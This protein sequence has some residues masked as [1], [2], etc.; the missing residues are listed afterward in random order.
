MCA[1]AEAKVAVHENKMKIN[2]EDNKAKGRWNQGGRRS[3]MAR[4]RVRPQ[5]FQEAE[6][7]HG[8]STKRE[9]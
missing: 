8:K 6:A 9:W 2:G 1:Y 3:R 7:R 4:R 5:Q